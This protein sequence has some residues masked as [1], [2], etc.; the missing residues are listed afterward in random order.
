MTEIE[1]E[2]QV[3][4]EGLAVEGEAHDRR[5]SDHSKRMLNLEPATAELLAML[6]RSSRRR[7]VLEIG[8]SNGYSTV[9]LAWAVGDG[10]HVISLDRSAEKQRMAA[11]NLAG[12]GLRDRVELRCGEAT[13][14]VSQ[15]EGG[16][17][18]VFF[19]ADRTSAPRQLET[20]LPILDQ[21]VLLL[22]DNAISHPEEISGYLMAV[23]SL[24]GVAHIVVPVGKGLSVAHRR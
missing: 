22:A 18:C 24:P 15:L 16:L 21:D 9:W 19:D 6:V 4:L 1:P 13:D 12:A 2:L 7:R 11:E 14:L 5:E 10:G 3:L 20:I 17:D 8:T 23:E